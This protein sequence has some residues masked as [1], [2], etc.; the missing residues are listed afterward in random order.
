MI[1]IATCQTN[2]LFILLERAEKEIRFSMANSMFKTKMNI[3]R[4]GPRLM[5]NQWKNLTHL[6]SR[7]QLP[8][9]ELNRKRKYSE[10]KITAKLKFK[11]SSIATVRNHLLT[12][13]QILDPS[14]FSL[15]T[16]LKHQYR[17]HLGRGVSYSYL[18]LV[19]LG[20]RLNL[21]SRG[22][23]EMEKCLPRTRIN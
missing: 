18:L 9:T 11:Q 16:T 7:Y 15:P 4:H 21:P 23:P 3:D 6:I 19:A 1:R 2:R 8:L 10:E 22:R 20:R 12:I 5:P 13:Y 14:Y 17:R